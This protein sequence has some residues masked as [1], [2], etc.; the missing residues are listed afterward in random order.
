M[1][2]FCL[3]ATSSDESKGGSGGEP[4]AQRGARGIGQQHRGSRAR[5]PWDQRWDVLQSQRQVHEWT[6]QNPTWVNN[7]FF[8]TLKGLILVIF[9]LQYAVFVLHNFDIKKWNTEWHWLSPSIF[10]YLVFFFFTSIVQPVLKNN[11]LEKQAATKHVASHSN[12][13]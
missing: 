9:Q 11:E 8:T 10:Y 3:A 7:F 6:A 12:C 13:K 5:S 2:S 1:F 4:C